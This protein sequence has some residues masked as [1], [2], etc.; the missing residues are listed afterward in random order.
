MAAEEGAGART[1]SLS[2]ALPGFAVPKWEG[3]A[4]RS[5]AAPRGRG[6]PRAGPARRAGR[7]W[8]GHG[9]GDSH[10]GPGRAAGAGTSSARDAVVPVRIGMPEQIPVPLGMLS[11]LS[12]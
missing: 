6:Q 3:S 5:R 2:P 12:G 9:A 11:Y 10:A 4:L 1:V 7:G 8:M